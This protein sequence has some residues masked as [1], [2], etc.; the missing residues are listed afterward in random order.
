MTQQ[1]LPRPERSLSQPCIRAGSPVTSNAAFMG[2]LRG[3]LP[4]RGATRHAEPR[5]GDGN[6]SRRANSFAYSGAWRL[7]LLALQGTRSTPGGDG[8]PGGNRTRVGGVQSRC[9]K[10]GP[11]VRVPSNRPRKPTRSRL[12]VARAQLT[13]M[14][15]RRRTRTKRSRAPE[16]IRPDLLDVVFP[17]TVRPLSEPIELRAPSTSC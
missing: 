13:G 11:W 14:K 7:A 16:S 1:L 6:L 8:T 17:R 15:S 4:G 3:S 9:S 10:D 2:L 5:S 12:A